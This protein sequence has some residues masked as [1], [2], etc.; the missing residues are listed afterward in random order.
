M[1]SIHNCRN[2]KIACPMNKSICL[3]NHE[4]E[5]NLIRDQMGFF[6]RKISEYCIHKI[7]HRTIFLSYDFN[8]K[9]LLKFVSQ[10]YNIIYSDMCEIL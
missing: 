1:I 7:N 6:R 4:S 3:I 8:T 2:D 5:I 10:N 9:D